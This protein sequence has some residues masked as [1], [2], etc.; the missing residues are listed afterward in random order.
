MAA[1][2]QDRIVFLET[3]EGDTT[4][5]PTW[6]FYLDR[7]DTSIAPHV[8]PSPGDTAIVSLLSRFFH[9]MFSG[10]HQKQLM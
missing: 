8:I 3:N 4:L 10:L 1:Q 6:W 7:A 5:V 2:Q 9:Q